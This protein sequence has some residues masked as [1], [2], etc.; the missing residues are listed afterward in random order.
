MRLEKWKGEGVVR[1]GFG[2]HGA[3]VVLRGKKAEEVE[4]SLTVGYFQRAGK[5]G[6][7]LRIIFCKFVKVDSACQAGTDTQLPQTLILLAQDLD[8]KAVEQVVEEDGTNR[9]A[10]LT[11]EGQA[12]LEAGLRMEGIDDSEKIMARVTGEHAMASGVEKHPLRM[13]ASHVG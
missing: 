13:V 5:M 12:I 4:K 7:I 6:E 3:V 10:G 9:T 2:G 8:G 1:N 11:E